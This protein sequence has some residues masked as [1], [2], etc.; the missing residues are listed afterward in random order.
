LSGKE[1]QIGL[2]YFS[3]FPTRLA[4]CR[5][6]LQRKHHQT[7]THQTGHSVVFVEGFLNAGYDATAGVASDIWLVRDAP[8]VEFRVYLKLMKQTAERQ[9]TPARVNILLGLDQPVEV[10]LVELK[11]QG[12]MMRVATITAKADGHASVRIDLPGK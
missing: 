5:F 7:A 2:F 4:G 12:E 1:N 10:P 3:G 8:A 11:R 6:S 9:A